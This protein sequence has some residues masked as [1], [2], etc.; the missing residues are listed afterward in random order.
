MRTINQTNQAHNWVRS[1]IQKR[2]VADALADD[3]RRRLARLRVGA[4]A[5]Q[6][7]RAYAR[8][9]TAAELSLLS[10]GKRIF[11]YDKIVEVM[12]ETGHD[13][14]PIYRETSKGGLAKHFVGGC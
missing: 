6:A 5:G 12:L 11:S 8:A 3:L 1:L 2:H 7:S 10:D 9:L 13:L 4:Q 14:P